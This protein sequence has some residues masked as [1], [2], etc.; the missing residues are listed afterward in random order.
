MQFSVVR[1]IANWISGSAAVSRI[2]EAVQLVAS[3][4]A[5]EAEVEVEEAIRGSYEQY[6][7]Y[8]S[9]DRFLVLQQRQQWL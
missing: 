2:A 8:R 3:A 6:T 4:A 9:K 1:S 7:V 5:A